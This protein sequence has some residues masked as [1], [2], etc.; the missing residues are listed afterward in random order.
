MNL[1][2]FMFAL[3]ILIILLQMH[4]AFA[5]VKQ[6]PSWKD[7]VH[8]QRIIAFVEL[9]TNDSAD[10]FVAPADRIAVFD[11]DGTLWSEQ[12]AYFQLYF[13]I[14]QIQNMAAAD[15]ALALKWKSDPVYS[16]VLENDFKGIMSHGE[17]GLLKI[18]GSSHSGMTSDEF[19]ASVKE[20]VSKAKHPETGRLFTE[21]VF[22]PM[23]EVLDYLRA[24]GFRVYIVSGGG[25][26]FIRP[27]AEDVYGIP[28]E[29]VIGSRLTSTYEYIDGVPVIK[30]N[31]ELAFNDDKAGKPVAI[32]EFIGKRPIMAFGN[33]DGDLQMLEWT[34]TNT[35][36]TLNVYIHHTDAQREWAYDLES[37]IGR[38]KQGLIDAKNNDWLVVDM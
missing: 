6:L 31:P 27:W 10:T 16:A 15:P 38:L 25:M 36:P 1:H 20:W 5:Q 29:N 18:I 8:S 14:D 26:D 11:N 34:A 30:K 37:H 19:E 12:P 35:K 24:N 21:M 9:V 17:E 28:K 33:S 3:S 4:S 2:R 22:Q 32:Y 7:N 13:A 23:L